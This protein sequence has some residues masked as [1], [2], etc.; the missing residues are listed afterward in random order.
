MKK[1]STD[2]WKCWKSKF[3]SS[4]NCQ[5]VDGCVDN[6]VIADKFRC[7]FMNTYKAN[8][9]GRANELQNTYLSMREKYYGLPT[10]AD[11]YFTT[12]A[13]SR[14]IFNLKR[15]KAADIDGL[16]AEHHTV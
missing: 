9:D 13:A 16:T 15:G 8:N 5:Q 12:E 6:E 1:N 11:N 4:N 10:V 7:Y 2:F 14:I 3:G